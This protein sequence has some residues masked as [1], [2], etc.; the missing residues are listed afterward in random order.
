MGEHLAC[1]SGYYDIAKTLMQNSVRFNIDY[2]GQTAFHLA[3]A[4]CKTST[5]ETL[6]ENAKDFNFDLT[7]KDKIGRT[8]FQVA[9]DKKCMHVTDLIKRKF[10]LLYKLVF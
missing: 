5:V 3:C 2:E 10:S 7:I 1:N 6:I 9:K 8:G 4:R